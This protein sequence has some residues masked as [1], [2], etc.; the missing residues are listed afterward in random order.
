MVMSDNRTL[1]KGEMLFLQGG[2]PEKVYLLQS[3]EI[4]ILYTPEEFI[5]LNRSIIIDKGI[6][7]CTIKGKTMLLGF[8]GLLVSKYSKSARAITDSEITEYSLGQEGFQWNVQHD[9]TGSINMLRQIFNIFMQSHSQFNKVQSLF[10]R[11]NQI[12]DNL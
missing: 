10:V 4:E 12:D 5:G 1:K 11:L 8:S 3:G 6:R 9:I 7:V 2:L